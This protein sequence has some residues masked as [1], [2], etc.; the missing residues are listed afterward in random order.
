MNRYKIRSIINN[1]TL[2]DLKFRIAWIDCRIIKNFRLHVQQTQSAQSHRN[3][4][5]VLE[6]FQDFLFELDMKPCMNEVRIFSLNNV[7][8]RP[9]SVGIMFF[10][11]SV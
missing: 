1:A 5:Y 9:C 7:I 3:R 10:S 4:E 2:L 8:V 11:S 6:S